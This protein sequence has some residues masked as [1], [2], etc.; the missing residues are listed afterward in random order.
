MDKMD[1]GRRGEK[2]KR[3]ESEAGEEDTLSRIYTLEEKLE[4]LMK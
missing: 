3:K 2:R 4:N 1:Q